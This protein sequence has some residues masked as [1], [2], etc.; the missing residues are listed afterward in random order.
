LYSKKLKA[1]LQRSNEWFNQRVGRFTASRISELLGVKGLGK[2]GE[3]YA[4]DMACEIVFGREEETFTSYDMQRGIELEPHAF[5]KFC[6]LNPELNVQESKFFP[7]GENAGA[8]PDGLV[9]LDA[10]LEIKCPKPAKLFR[11]IAQGVEAIDP[12]YI[13]QMQM[14]MMC[15]NSDKAYFFNYAIFNGQ[16]V[17]HTLEV[18][19]D[20]ERIKLISDRI[21]QAVEIR[22]EFVQY[23]LT[24]KQF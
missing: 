8:S 16:T 3:T 14:Q 12:A 13:D 9:G 10:V 18:S 22:D 4:F 23:L 5:A 17:W 2:T 6:E 1:M 7:H 15:T 11:L 20:D 19:R 21:A 24:E